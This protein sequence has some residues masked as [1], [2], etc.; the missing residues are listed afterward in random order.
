MGVELA[1]APSPSLSLTDVVRSLEPSL[2]PLPGRVTV[3]SAEEDM[4]RLRDMW[5]IHLP[6]LLEGVVKSTDAW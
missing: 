6:Y 3:R 4:P 1:H 5:I 2:Q